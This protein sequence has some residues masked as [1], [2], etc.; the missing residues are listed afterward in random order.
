MLCV[1]IFFLFPCFLVVVFFLINNFELEPNTVV[2]QK[3]TLCNEQK[4]GRVLWKESTNTPSACS[5]KK[6]I[7]IC[8]SA[9]SAY[10]AIEN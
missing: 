10:L 2:M 9:Y 8:I 1:P 4:L 6:Y 5:K 7:Y 3:Y